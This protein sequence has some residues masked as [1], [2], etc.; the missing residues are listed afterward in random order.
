MKINAITRAF[1]GACLVLTCSGQFAL[2]QTTDDAP[3][4]G[5]VKALERIEITGTHIKGVDMEGAQPLQVI[6]ADAIKQSGASSISELLQDIAV[7]RGGTGSFSTA[8]SGALQGDSPVGQ[9]AASLRGLGA[10]STLTL[11]N[12]RRVAASSFANKFE[13][14]VDVNAI[15]LAAI[16]RIEILAT[17]ASAT[18][19]ADAVAGVI[20]YIL[21]KDFDGV[22]VNASY[23]D[24]TASSDDG[25]YNLNLVAGHNFDGGNITAFADYYKRNPLM[26]RDREETAHSFFP[27]QQ[28]IWP[29]IN[30]DGPVDADASGVTRYG[31]FYDDLVEQGCPAELTKSGRFGAYC[32]Y[33]QNQYLPTNP[34]LEQWAGGLNLNVE[35]GDATWF[36]EVMLSRTESSANSTGAP[37]SGERFDLSHPGLPADI[38]DGLLFNIVDNFDYIYFGDAI[39][40]L[41]DYYGTSGYD[42]TLAAVVDDTYFLMWGRF[43]DGRTLENK[44]DTLRFV[45]GLEGQ[46]DDWYYKGA[47]SYSNSESEQRAVA[48][49]IDRARFEAAL[50][51]RLCA[52]GSTD[53]RPSTGGL[54]YNPFAGQAQNSEEVMALLNQAVPRNGESKLFTADFSVSGDLMMLP[55]GALSAAFGAEYRREE[56]SDSPDPI[57]RGTAQ[58]N[59]EPGVIGFGSTGADAERNTY[60]L[61]AEFHVPVTEALNLQVAGRYDHYDDFGGDFNPKLALRYKA[62]E[63]LILRASWATSFR[64]PSLSQVG[65][66]VTL[67]SF[68]LQCRDEFV[69][70]YCSG[71]ESDITILTREVGNEDLQA[72][73]STSYNAGFAY[74]PTEDMDITL[75]YW[76]FEHEDIVGIDGEFFLLRS[77]TD[78]SLRK[79][80]PVPAGELGVGFEGCIDGVGDL[81]SRLDG[82]VAI[83]LENLGRQETHGLDLTFTQY[84][85]GWTLMADVTHLLG[86]ERQL[87]PLAETEEL[88]DSFRYPETIATAKVKWSSGDW[89]AGLTARY[90]SDYKDDVEGLT[91]ADF[92]RLG[93]NNMRRVP[94][95]TVWDVY[96][97]VDLSTNAT[98]TLSVDNL[99]DRD[100]PTAY[101]TSANVDHFNHSTLGTFYKLDIAYR[102]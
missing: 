2:A 42:D 60:G 62:S 14:F 29:S 46:W 59:Y 34:A 10:A 33:D 52:D 16:E 18:Y 22:A 20:N 95:W 21:K 5:E 87:S 36:T 63:D 30:F 55:A 83:Q 24:S 25:K 45:T 79:C 102:F 74:S 44:T 66:E 71:E 89:F 68:R 4:E 76:R 13:N 40:G 27:S 90:T 28:G 7:T 70:N 9:A 91:D 15:P 99:F 11:I 58:N 41:H 23:G 92:E 51:G 43:P 50:R 6:S 93:I 98:L 81:N 31:I 82:D 96:A 100:A 17:G 54:Y 53:C 39:D 77:L 61:F 94:S 101:G 12:G 84:L 65:A 67:S 47:V 49:I 78:P 72:E 37:F 75:D 3:Q 35:L 80:G 86:F 88:A 69:G 19:G 64:A 8:T 1:G 85:G 48:G 38:R 73:T 56:I 32:E 97:G 57:A 26:D